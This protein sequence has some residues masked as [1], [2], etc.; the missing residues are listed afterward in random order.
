MRRYEKPACWGPL[1]LCSEEFNLH[2]KAFH[3]RS[4]RQTSERLFFFCGGG[5]RVGN[6]HKLIKK[7][8]VLCQKRDWMEK[9]W[10]S[11]GSSDIKPLT[12]KYPQSCHELL[13]CHTLCPLTP[14]LREAPAPAVGSMDGPRSSWEKARSIITHQRNGFSDVFDNRLFKALQFKGCF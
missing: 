13:A 14:R 9:V 8:S 10:L 4:G 7:Y 11:L 6:T 2:V 5:G 1:Q 3:W 12:R